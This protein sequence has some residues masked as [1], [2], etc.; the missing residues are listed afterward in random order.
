MHRT[1]TIDISLFVSLPIIDC[2]DDLFG[3]TRREWQPLHIEC[4][5]DTIVYSDLEYQYQY[6]LRN[7]DIVL[8][9]MI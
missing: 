1:G 8:T 5:R 7:T 6:R 3:R 2:M 4:K 9:V